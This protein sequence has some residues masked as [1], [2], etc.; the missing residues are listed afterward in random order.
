M[1]D[2]KFA[3]KGIFLPK[4]E[5]GVFIIVG[6]LNFSGDAGDPE[7]ISRPGSV[8]LHRFLR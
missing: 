3:I 8:V 7:L 2:F 4:E 6:A 5:F 1:G